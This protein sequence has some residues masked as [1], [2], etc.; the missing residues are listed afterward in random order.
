MLQ[1][2]MSLTDDG[3]TFVD[4]SGYFYRFQNKADAKRFLSGVDGTYEVIQGGKNWESAGGLTL[5]A[6]DR[7]IV[8]PNGDW[9]FHELEATYKFSPE[10]AAPSLPATPEEADPSAPT[11]LYVYKQNGML[12]WE[13]SLTDDGLTFVDKSGYFYRFQNKADAKRFLSGVDGTYE[14]IQGGKDWENA[15]GLTL[16]ASDRKIVRPNGDWP[17]HEN[18]ASYE[19]SPAATR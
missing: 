13:M 9:P 16:R 12:Q 19:F 1:W 11:T 4:K 8:R 3:L 7:K 6:S 18:D 17:F 14:V 10:E 2:E 15:G 5:R